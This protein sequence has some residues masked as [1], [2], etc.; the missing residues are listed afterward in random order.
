MIVVRESPFMREACQEDGLFK[1]FYRFGLRW[2]LRFSQ[3]ESSF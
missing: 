1:G 3:A 2:D